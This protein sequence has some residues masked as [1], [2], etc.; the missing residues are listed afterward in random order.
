MIWKEISL[1]NAAPLIL[2]GKQIGTMEYT[3]IASADILRI[4]L[5]NGIL[6]LPNAID[7]GEQSPQPRIFVI[8]N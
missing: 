1:N 8:E 7:I 4:R 5:Q 6:E 3:R 2:A